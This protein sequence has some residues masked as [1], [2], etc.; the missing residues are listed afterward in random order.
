MTEPMELSLEPHDR[1]YDPPL[2]DHL[3]RED[4]CFAIHLVP[5]DTV[6]DEEKCLV[7]V[8]SDSPDG[9]RITVLLGRIDELCASGRVL[10]IIHGGGSDYQLATEQSTCSL[11]DLDG[12]AGSEIADRIH[13]IAEVAEYVYLTQVR[14]KARSA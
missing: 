14:T 3:S 12:A 10:R 2:V 8:A 1:L 13:Q 9:R 11:S 5:S 4:D 7:R 6:S